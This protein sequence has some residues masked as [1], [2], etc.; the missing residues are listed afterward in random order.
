MTKRTAGKKR[1]NGNRKG[2]KFEREIATLL[3]LWWTNGEHDDRFW[4][5]PNSGGRATLRGQD[6][7]YAHGDITA[8]H[9]DG[10][11]LL[12][13]ITFELKNGYDKDGVGE[14]LE[15]N[16]GGRKNAPK[17]AEFWV[18][19]GEAASESQSFSHMLI[20]KRTR[21]SIMAWMPRNLAFALRGLGVP[22]PPIRF[23]WEAELIFGHRLEDWLLEVSRDHIIEIANRL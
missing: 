12:D 8:T 19:S 14:I 21:R 2:G 15:F 7:V 3:S 11:P 6:T 22:L 1:R 20:T 5:T 4:R 13:V 23:Y 18:Q 10:Y 17:W 16:Y 9:P